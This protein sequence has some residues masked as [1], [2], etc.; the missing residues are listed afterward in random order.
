MGI[1]SENV[2]E[3]FGI[4]RLEHDTLA[5]ASN[6]RAIKAQKLGLYTEIVPV[7]TKVIDKDGNEK[8]VTV[9][10]DEGPREGTTL[11]GLAKLPGAFK[12]G[13]NTTAGNSSQVSDGAAAVLL[14]KRSK[15]KELG[16]K[17]IARFL[18]MSVIGVPPNIMGI[19]YRD[20]AFA[21]AI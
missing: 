3:Q 13:G 21:S 2:A 8:V 17:P 19:G 20:L 4:S 6:E 16:I 15:A 7:T 11:E 1:T 10:K 14:M 18:S 12:K 9:V 5:V